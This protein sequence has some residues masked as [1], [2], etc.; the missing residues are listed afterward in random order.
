MGEPIVLERAALADGA[1]RADDAALMAAVRA[2]EREAF[3]RLVERHKDAVVNYLTRLTADRDRAEDLAQETFLRLWRAPRY[4]EQGKLLPFLFRIAT[5]LVRTEERRAR[6]WRL[7]AAVLPHALAPA[8]VPA[9]S[10]DPA[11]HAERHEL[12]GR[13]VRAIAALPL[14]YRVPLVM[15]DVEELSYDEI[16]AALGC[17]EGTVKSRINRARTLLR[18][19]LAPA[20]GPGDGGPRE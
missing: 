12:R 8:A 2:G 6:R 11:A 5:N 17:P 18:E 1:V 10:A 13:L 15:R 4:D 16:A 14:T 7:I 9:P 19:Q 3:A 20:R